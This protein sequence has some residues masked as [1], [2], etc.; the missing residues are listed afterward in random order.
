MHTC[1]RCESKE[2]SIVAK[3]PVKDA[4]EVYLCPVCIFTWRSIEPETTI[5]PEKYNRAFKVNPADIPFSENVPA[6]P[7]KY[8]K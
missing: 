8:Q 1:P 7:E 3:S 6:L 2:A 5:N 4:W